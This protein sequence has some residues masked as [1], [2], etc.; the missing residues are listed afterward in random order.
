MRSEV[1]NVLFMAV[2]SEV[3]VV[4]GIGWVL[5]VHLTEEYMDNSCP[6]WP[7][8]LAISQ[9]LWAMVTMSTLATSIGSSL[10]ET[11]LSDQI[12]KLY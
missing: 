1:L 2:F 9:V 12:T 6:Y 11:R 3:G 10:S 8:S 7:M 4:P 5:S